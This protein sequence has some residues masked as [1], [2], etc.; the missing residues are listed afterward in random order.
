MSTAEPLGIIA[1]SRTLPFLIAGEAR[2]GG[3]PKIVAV[4]FEGETDPNL[5]TLVDEIVWL[6]VGQLSKMIKA[7]EE[8]RG[9]RRETLCNGRADYAEESFRFTPGSACDA[10]P[11]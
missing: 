5:A 11:V 4:A 9:A 8:L 6:R 1:G 10:P 3:V 2:K 7:F